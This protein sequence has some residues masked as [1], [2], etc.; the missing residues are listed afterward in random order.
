M[1]RNIPIALSFAL[2]A[3]AIT[4]TAFAAS[5]DAPAASE[6]S[7]QVQEKFMKL[8]G[9][10]KTFEKRSNDSLY[11]LIE[12]EE[13]VFGIV[14]DERTVVVDNV[15]NPV[16]LEEGMEF[17]AFV[18]ADKP[19]IMVYPPQYSPELVVVQTKEPGFVEVDQFDK[20]FAGK[21]LKL[22]LSKETVIENLSGKKLTADAVAEAH[23]AVF[24][25]ASTRSIPAQTTP[26]KVIV[27][28][29]DEGKS[30]QEIVQDIM[31]QDFYEVDGV[32]MIPLRLVAEQLGWTVESTGKGAVVT[33]DET[34]FTITR[35]AKAYV[36]NGKNKQ[37]K[38]APA[39]LEPIKT[40]V[41]EEF[42]EYLLK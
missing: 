6:E 37:F 14:V 9:T 39:L 42:V 25:T 40:Y 23:A 16:K 12:K 18:D 8:T 36:Y 38:A 28:N 2:V 24:Y 35:G 20:E 19:M 22:N 33:K 5:S 15:G 10:I 1:K 7:E 11:A 34:T 4:P 17:T 26:S 13:D 21:K 30:N 27:L 32:K 3:G 41:P 31:D 29:A